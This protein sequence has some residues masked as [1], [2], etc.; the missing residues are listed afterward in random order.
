MWLFTLEPDSSLV[1]YR[2]G[3]ACCMFVPAY[4]QQW[5][6]LANPFSS[7]IK[8]WCKK[9]LPCWQLLVHLFAF[10]PRAAFTAKDAVSGVIKFQRQLHQRITRQ[11]VEVEQTASFRGLPAT[12]VGK[13]VSSMLSIAKEKNLGPGGY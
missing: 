7:L 3:I 11:F 5:R 2:T 6:P 4:V 12:Q 13:Y 8:K 9:F 1:T 10:S